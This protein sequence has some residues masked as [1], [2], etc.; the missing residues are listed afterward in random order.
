M[1]Q[2]AGAPEGQTE[3]EISEV[4]PEEWIQFLE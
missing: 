1:A 3:E 4:D 2:R